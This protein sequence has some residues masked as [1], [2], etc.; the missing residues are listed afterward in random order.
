M[1]TP[2]VGIDPGQ[3]GALV[4]ISAGCGGGP[5]FLCHKMPETEKDVW[6]L[7][8]TLADCCRSEA[9]PPT[10]VIELVHSSPQMGVS[11][12]F[13]FGRGL[14]GIR[15][16][17][18]GNGFVIHEVTPQKWK[19]VMRCRSAKPHALGKKDMTVVRARAQEL[20]PLVKIT[21]W[22]AD[23]LMIAAYGAQLLRGAT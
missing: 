22:N 11:S 17:L 21:N 6:D 5:E 2:I 1:P 20:Y 14:G 19:S 4:Y 23:A 3:S 13:T 15:M 12:S 7:V 16:A 18:I 10:A 8:K 9:K